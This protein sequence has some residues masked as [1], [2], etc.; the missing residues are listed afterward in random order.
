LTVKQWWPEHAELVQSLNT[1]LTTIEQLKPQVSK[2]LPVRDIW[3]TLVNTYLEGGYEDSSQNTSYAFATFLTQLLSTDDQERIHAKEVLETPRQAS[4]LGKT[5]I[6][7]IAEESQKFI[8][9]LDEKDRIV[10]STQ[11]MSIFHEL[12]HDRPDWIRHWIEVASQTHE[13]TSSRLI[14]AN[15]HQITPEVFEM[16]IQI[17]PTAVP[18]VRK[19]LLEALKWQ[20]RTGKVP[21]DRSSFLAEQILN[22]FQQETDDTL[23]NALLGL[24]SAWRE[25][26]T[27]LTIGM[28]LLKEL[29]AL[30]GRQD[31]LAL[32]MAL[33]HLAR[34]QPALLEPVQALLRQRAWTYAAALACL[35]VGDPIEKDNRNVSEGILAELE[36]YI[37]DSARCFTALLEAGSDD[38]DW[39]ERRYHGLLVLAARLLLEYAPDSLAFTLLRSLLQRVEQAVASRDW[40]TGRMAMAIVAACA[41]TMPITLQQA[42]EGKLEQLLVKS[43]TDAE[44]FHMRRF[45]LTALSY[46][47]TVRTAIIPALLAG[48]RDIDVVQQDAIAAAGRF[49]SIEGNFLPALLPAL[50]GESASTAYAVAHLLGALGT[51]AAGTSAGLPERIFTALVEALNAPGRLRR[52]IIAGKN[53]GTLED[54]LYDVLLR[55]AGWIG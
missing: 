14:L 39:D 40:P 17:W 19:L 44:S 23:R 12:T 15:M 28:F 8:A 50:W 41:E 43:T 29:E 53:I 25:G 38:A 46:L 52:V 21:R 51:S 49:Q 45:A 1:A 16:L 7:A 48:C 54:I 6:E 27:A 32:S 10:V 4:A 33:A 36:S 2:I 24:L 18:H 22:W 13:K 31:D 30:Q 20:V 26:K 37:P 3:F 55:I 34:I 42:S 35:C 9:D 5:R 47:R 11:V